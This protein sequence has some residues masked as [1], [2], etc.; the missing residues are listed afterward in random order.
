MISRMNVGG[1][2]TLLAHLAE[3]LPNS[4]FEHILI[5]G[6]CEENEF[7]FLDINDFQG[8]FI[9]LGG[10]GRA[11]NFFSLIRDF[12]KTI[13]LLRKIRPDIVH[14]HTTKAGII[15]RLATWIFLPRAKVVHTFHG[16]LLYG[17]FKKTRI[18][19]LI[20]VE[21]FLARISDALVSVSE[22][23]QQELITAGVGILS[24]WTVIHPGV[25]YQSLS[26][27]DPFVQKEKSNRS[28]FQMIWI[29]RFTDIKNPMLAI[30]SYAALDKQVRDSIKFTM[31]GDGELLDS[32]K[33]FSK[34]HK[35]GINFTGWKKDVSKIMVQSDV[36]LLTSKNEGLP[37][38][39]VESAHFSVPTIATPV[40]GVIDFI[41]DNK[42]GFLASADKEAISAK[43]LSV[44]ANSRLRKSVGK[45]AMCLADTE[46]SSTNFINRH[47]KLY[48]EL[49]KRDFDE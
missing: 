17:Y 24:N 36:L 21:K 40:G 12:M 16:H 41:K 2:A 7:D 42:T 13:K 26:N 37:V 49:V 10:S 19:W 18:N 23:V 3:N 4:E 29:G 38:V 11:G 33:K 47:I 6:R 5:T 44:F 28:K 20:S 1:P 8:K 39:I 43:I 25:D 32:C 15:G 45:N 31:V 35:L 46:Y 14:T 22:T 34:S 9:Y 30:N 48:E 27:Q